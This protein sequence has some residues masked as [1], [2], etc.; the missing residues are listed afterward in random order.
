[1]NLVPDPLGAVALGNGRMLSQPEE[2]KGV[3]LGH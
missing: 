1:V 3:R 2:L